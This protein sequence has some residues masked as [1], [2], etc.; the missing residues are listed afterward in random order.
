MSGELFQNLDCMDEDELRAYARTLKHAIGR[1]RSRVMRRVLGKL[2]SYARLKGEAMFE[3]K[4][5]NMMMGAAV[6]A[7][8]DRVYHSLPAF[9]RW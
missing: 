8:C 9:A 5:G 4:A 2:I 1:E 7:V 6:D 3:Y